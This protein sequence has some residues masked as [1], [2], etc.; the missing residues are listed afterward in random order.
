AP[1]ACAATGS[2]CPS[3]SR[4]SSTG[5]SPRRAATTTTSTAASPA[6]RSTGEARTTSVCRR[7][8][9]ACAAWAKRTERRLLHPPP[10]LHPQIHQDGHQSYNQQGQQES[11][12]AGPRAQFFHRRAEEVHAKKAGQES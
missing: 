6:T 12:V 10:P 2:S 11:C 4:K 1:A 8:W 7:S 3:P 9:R 5:W